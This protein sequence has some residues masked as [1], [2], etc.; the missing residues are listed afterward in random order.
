[1]TDTIFAFSQK[2]Q[3]LIIFMTKTYLVFSAH[4]DD[5]DFGSSGTVA[6]LTAQGNRVVYYI[7]SDGRK[8]KSKINVSDNKIIKLR[9][10]EQKEAG[11]IVGVEQVIFLGE[12]DGEVENTRA[13]RK[14]LAGVIRKIKPDIILSFDPA[15]LSFDNF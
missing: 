9:Q 3:N 13:L 7:I 6:K 1:M 11:R 12:K 2:W 14:E 8:G 4:P 10:K 15:S 5:L